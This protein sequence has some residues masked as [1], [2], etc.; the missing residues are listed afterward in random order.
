[1]KLILR[2][3][4]AVLVLMC[5]V[6]A[7]YWPLLMKPGTE[8]QAWQVHSLAQIGYLVGAPV[9]ALSIW[10][11]GGLL[12]LAAVLWSAYIYWLAGM[13]CKRDANSRKESNDTS[14]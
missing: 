5:T 8:L 2:M 6:Q 9:M 14:A 13:A 3:G 7:L 12:V 1:M 4:L 10:L 11:N